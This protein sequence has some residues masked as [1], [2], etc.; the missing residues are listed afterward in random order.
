LRPLQAL[1]G[2]IEPRRALNMPPPPPT[3]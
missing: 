1:N 3:Q 2:R